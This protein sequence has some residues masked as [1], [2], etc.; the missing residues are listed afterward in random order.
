M[1]AVY[2]GFDTETTGLPNK[3]LP[4][5]HHMQP[6]VIQIACMLTDVDGNEL[7]SMNKLIKPEG[8]ARIDPGAEKAHG[9]SFERCM[10]EGKPRK[11][12][13][14]EFI[15]LVKPAWMLIAHNNWFDLQLLRFTFSREP[16]LDA[17]AIL[18][19]EQFCSMKAWT[20]I[21]KIPPTEKMRY[22]GFGPYKNASLTEVHM[23]CFGET[24]DKAHDAMNDVRAMMKCFFKL[25]ERP[26]P[27][28]S[29]GQTQ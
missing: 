2:A 20:P 9:I 8:F 19:K 10:D 26:R 25:P 16:S 24:F 7:G 15:S 23:H 6:H 21:V 18:G 17:P 29:S 14:E 4:I 12:V 5:H 27:P 11:E 22:Y 1:T 28:A 13:M 3:K